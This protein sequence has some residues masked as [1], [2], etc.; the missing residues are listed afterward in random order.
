MKIALIG[1]MNNNNFAIMRYFRDLG[2]D[3]YLLLYKGDGSRTLSQFRPENDTWELDKWAPYIIQTEVGNAPFSVLGNPERLIFPYQ[4]WCYIK[5]LIKFIIGR[6]DIRILPPSP[7]DLLK[8][9]AGFDRYI[10]S[11]LA[12][13]IL[14]RIGIT[15]DIFYPYSTGIEFLGNKEFLNE[16]NCGKYLTSEMLKRIEV[17]QR[18]GVRKASICLNA[19]MSL[20]RETFRT[21]HIDFRPLAVPMIYNRGKYRNDNFLPM[22]LI[23]LKKELAGFDFNVIMH[24]RQRWV[25]PARYS[26]AEWKSLSKNN[27]WLLRAYAAFL[28]A[29]PSSNCQLILLEYG[30]D[31]ECTKKLCAE[32]RIERSVKWL[33]QMPRRDLMQIIACCDVGVGEFQT[34]HG[35]IWG[36]TGWEILASGKPLLQRYNF[37]EGEFETVFGYPP[38]PMLPVYEA[39]SI[40]PHLIDMADHPEKREAIGQAAS[41]WFDRYNGIGLAQQWLDL[42]ECSN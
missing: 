42:L 21:N 1:N 19:E 24:S 27:D 35:I 7:N 18:N 40:L 25:K 30:P 13:A 33:P 2:V 39:D 31:S 8:A 9:F 20:T 5:Y 17:A 34:D 22:H 3:A 29:R 16:I 41:D 32:L 28:T 15:L 37:D 11:G 36:G 26:L 10:G 14:N 23:T 4:P 6:T 38:P 12:P